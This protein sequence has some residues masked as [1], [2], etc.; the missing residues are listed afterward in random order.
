MLTVPACKSCNGRKSRHDDFLRDI[1][2]T[3]IAASDLPVARELFH[4]KVLRSH[5]QGKSLAVRIALNESQPVPYLTRDG[6][7]DVAFVSRFDIDRADEMFGFI[8]RGLYFSRFGSPL[9]STAQ[10]RVRRLFK[11]DTERMISI[12]NQVGVREVV[13]IGE[14]VF[15]CAYNRGSQ[16]PET[17]MWFLEFY[18]SVCFSAL[19][20]PTGFFPGQFN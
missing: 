19:T 6:D 18:D 10:I 7:A 15:S 13:T 5:M 16:T 2:V 4:A 20:A 3:D 8:V 14:S 1:L 9:S 12:F 11:Q 17:S